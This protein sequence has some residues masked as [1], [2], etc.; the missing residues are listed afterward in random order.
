MHF[1]SIA[2]T[3]QSNFKWNEISA[4]K[5]EAALIRFLSEVFIAVASLLP[6]LPVSYPVHKQSLSIVVQR[7]AGQNDCISRS[8]LICRT[9]L[10]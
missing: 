5:F 2:N 9:P 1:K 6:K 8:C 7:S 10:S 3:W 4:I